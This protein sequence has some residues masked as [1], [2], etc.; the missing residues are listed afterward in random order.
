MVSNF[1]TILL[2]C[3]ILFYFPICKNETCILF[4]LF[5]SVW[6]AVGISSTQ[7]CRDM[8]ED[9]QPEFITEQQDE[10]KLNKEIDD[11]LN[12]IDFQSSMSQET[13]PTCIPST[14]PEEN[15]ITNSQHDEIKREEEMSSPLLF[16]QEKTEVYHEK[17]NTEQKEQ[18][19]SAAILQPFTCSEE[20][21][22]M[23]YDD[24][25]DILEE[26]PVA[27]IGDTYLTDAQ[28]NEKYPQHPIDVS[29]SQQLL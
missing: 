5:I 3:F 2:T 25:M 6:N 4:I 10:Q 24:H 21:N 22:P 7:L 12:G 18:D 1:Y 26:V 16:T 29:I 20:K 11:L 8:M 13:S 23:F 9:M 28:F 27:D 15:S 14:Y 17:M 19:T